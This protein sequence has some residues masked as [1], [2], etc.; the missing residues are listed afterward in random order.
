MLGALDE[1][2]VDD[3]ACFGVETRKDGC[4]AAKRSE[5]GAEATSAGGSG[6]VAIRLPGAA[7]AAAVDASTETVAV[8]SLQSS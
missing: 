4:V 6:R 5:G 1:R 3:G 2:L 8:A 7:T